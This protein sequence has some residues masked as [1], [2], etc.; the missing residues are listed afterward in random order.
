[1][2]PAERALLVALAEEV[3]VD[4]L[5]RA[6]PYDYNSGRRIQQLLRSL[7]AEVVIDLAPTDRPAPDA[8]EQPKG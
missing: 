3:A 7:N 1:M 8:V 5:Y 2:T 6:Q 4:L